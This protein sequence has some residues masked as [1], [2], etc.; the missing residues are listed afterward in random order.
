MFSTYCKAAIKLYQ[1][2]LLLAAKHLEKYVVALNETVI[3]N[4]PEVKK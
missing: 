4:D 2:S 1:N 3:P